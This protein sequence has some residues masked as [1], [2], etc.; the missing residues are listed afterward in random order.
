MTEY[1]D[2]MIA[3]LDQGAKDAEIALA[4]LKAL[5]AREDEAT[6][7]N[8]AAV[9]EAHAQGARDRDEAR[10]MYAGV[11]T[12]PVVPTPEPVPEPIH[13]PT[14]TPAPR[15]SSLPVTPIAALEQEPPITPELPHATDSET[16]AID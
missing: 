6:A 3:L 7:A 10:K 5:W 13:E 8:R 2:R 14:P 12:P 15:M 16:K 1:S 11:V 9:L 4:D